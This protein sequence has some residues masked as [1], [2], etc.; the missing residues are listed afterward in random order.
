MRFLTCAVLA[1]GLL[2]APA[3]AQMNS[4]VPPSPDQF[5]ADQIPLDDPPAGGQADQPM[6]QPQGPV[7][8]WRSCMDEAR[9]NGLQGDALV[10]ARDQCVI[11]A[12]PD[13]EV[14][15]ECRRD[16]RAAGLTGDANRLAVRQCID[17]AKPRT[18][19]LRRCRNEG[20]NRGLEGQRLMSFIRACR[21]RGG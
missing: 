1:F 15:V 11:Q 12:R 4:P 13:L 6:G 9:A 5:P 2:V 7:T 16:A 21:N 10:D 19:L 3:A 14:D 20:L 8:I 17:A 18:A